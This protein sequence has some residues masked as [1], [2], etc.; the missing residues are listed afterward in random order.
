MITPANARNHR[1]AHLSLETTPPTT[2]FYGSRNVLASESKAVALLEGS[3]LLAKL[4]AHRHRS[5]RHRP[6]IDPMITRAE[7]RL[8]TSGRG[9]S[10]PRR[11][12]D[13][14]ANVC[15]AHAAASLD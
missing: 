2:G 5:R 15:I 9:T 13:A 6:L 4:R 12:H 11:D 1:P 7:T 3:R 10:G 14:R 8:A